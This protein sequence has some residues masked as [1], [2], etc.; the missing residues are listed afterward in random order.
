MGPDGTIIV[1]FQTNDRSQ[2]QDIEQHIEDET[3]QNYGPSFGVESVES[4]AGGGGGG[5][6]SDGA[7]AA[8]VIVSVCCCCLCCLIIVI[9]VII[10]VVSSGKGSSDGSWGSAVSSNPLWSRGS[11]E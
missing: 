11:T 7:I 9:V 6:L 1:R 10:L 4:D 2:A 5:G 8:I 3:E